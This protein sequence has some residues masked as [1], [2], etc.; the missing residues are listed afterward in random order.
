[1]PLGL[2]FLGI[3]GFLPLRYGRQKKISRL[4]HHDSV[5]TAGLYP[6]I[7]EGDRVEKRGEES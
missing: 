2:I 1:M 3:V 4:K 6:I 5:T 7:D